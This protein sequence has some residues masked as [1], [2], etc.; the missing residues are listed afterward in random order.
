MQTVLSL[1]V[2]LG[3]TAA[4][5]ATGIQFRP[6]AWYEAL[7]KPE[8][9]PPNWLFPPVW[10]VLYIMIAIAGWRVWLAEG[11][12]RATLIWVV[13]LA[14]NAA[15]SFIMFG[16]HQ[17]ALAAIDIVALLVAIVAFIAV[18][19]GVDKLAMALFVPYLAWVSYAAA[20]NIA[21]LRLN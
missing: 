13:A 1:I 21:I 19:S 20:L 5:A 6:G 9:T 2:F 11:L 12:G 15:W 17:I 16:Q 8:W 4:A 10:T 7:A 3:L 18:A 14:L